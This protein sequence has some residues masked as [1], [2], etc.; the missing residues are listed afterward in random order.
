MHVKKLNK[1]LFFMLSVL[2]LLGLSRFSNNIDSWIIDISSH[3]SFQYALVAL[4]FIFI[5]LWKRIFL[6]TVMAGFIFVLNITAIIDFGESIHATEYNG[7]LLKV[8]SANLHLNNYELSKFN[9]EIQ[10][11]EPDIILLLEVTPEH[12]AQIEPVVQTY[13]YHI[14]ERDLGKKDIGFI[15]LSRYPI[16]NSHLTRLT[17]ICNFVIEAKLEIKQKQVMF[18]GIHAWRPNIESF[19]NRKNQFLWLADQ[20][21][22]QSLPVI[23]AGDFNATPYSPIFRAIVKTTGLK[24]SREGFG[25]QP[26]WPTTFPPLWIPIDHILVTS[27]FQI[28]K[29]TTGSYIGSDH[30]PV[31]AE[32]SLG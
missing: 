18:Y 17:D 2:F 16:L 12:F 5:C 20:I 28:L 27:D 1:F 3:F 23:V 29:R 6:L 10:E 19:S 4:V 15:M 32:L 14:K 22:K 7:T 21:K 30:Y 8:Y 24:D 11:I 9:Q 31:T 13:P 25:W 26:S